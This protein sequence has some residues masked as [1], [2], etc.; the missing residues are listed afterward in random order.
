MRKLRLRK[1]TLPGTSV[2]VLAL[3]CALAAH[4]VLLVGRY[5]TASAQRKLSGSGI[6]M[7]NLAALPE[8]E[9]R[10]LV[11]WIA[12]HDPARSVRSDSPSGYAAHL[13]GP[14]PRSVTVRDFPDNT[15]RPRTAVTPFAPVPTRPA[16]IRF[17]PDPPESPVPFPEISRRVRVLDQDG[18]RKFETLFS[19]PA[20]AAA[21]KPSVVSLAR[22]G[23]AARISLLRSCGKPELDRLAAAAASKIPP[24]KMPGTLLFFWP[25]EVKK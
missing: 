14:P 1:Q 13:P 16:R 5:K 18:S 3:L 22:I 6:E 11:R 12:V 20:N 23:N 17:V 9:R 8:A 2:A 25:P 4:S 7:L 10:N 15:A 19:F 24:E 21:A